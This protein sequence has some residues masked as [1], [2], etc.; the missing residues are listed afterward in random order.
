M[1]TTSN[2]FDNHHTEENLLTHEEI[3][4]ELSKEPLPPK[5]VLKPAI[6]INEKLKAADDKRA[7]TIKWGAIRK[8]EAKAGSYGE[9]D[10][11]TYSTEDFVQDFYSEGDK[12]LFIDNLLLNLSICHT[13]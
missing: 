13:A 6:K 8:S 9:F 4:L 11:K 2:G 10:K 12:K 7:S 1:N 3:G 5:G